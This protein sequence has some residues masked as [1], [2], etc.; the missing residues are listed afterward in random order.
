MTHPRTWPTD[1]EGKFHR[2]IWHHVE[3]FQD[4]I[5]GTVEKKICCGHKAMTRK[6]FRNKNIT[7]LT[8]H[9]VTN[10]DKPSNLTHNYELI[11]LLC[12]RKYDKV[13]DCMLHTFFCLFSV[14]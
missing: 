2:L 3:E 8:T 4:K 7:D 11:M 10:G 9:S 1:R 14:F 12:K 5:V 13:G 6:R